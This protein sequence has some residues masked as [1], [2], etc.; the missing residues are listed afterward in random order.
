LGDIG[1]LK[2]LRRLVTAV[3]S[4]TPSVSLALRSGV[5]YRP[6]ETDFVMAKSI[7]CSEWRAIGS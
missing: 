1:L 6:T 4:P 3:V 5:S 7:D 2:V